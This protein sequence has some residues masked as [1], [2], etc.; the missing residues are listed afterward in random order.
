MDFL[1]FDPRPEL[2]DTRIWRKLL[3]IILDPDH[4]ERSILLQKYFWTLRSAGT[5]IQW[6]ANGI[7]LLPLIEP[8]GDWPDIDFFNSIKTK[9]LGPHAAEVRQLLELAY[10]EASA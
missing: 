9:Y 3:L 5:M 2:A 8:D 7:K 10:R 6:N 4:K 1:F